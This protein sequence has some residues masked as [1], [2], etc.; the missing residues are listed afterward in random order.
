MRAEPSFLSFRILRS[1]HDDCYDPPTPPSAR[2]GRSEP[3][4]HPYFEIVI[5]SNY[6]TAV[7]E[8][9]SITGLLMLSPVRFFLF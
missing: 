3:T 7:G 4:L 2:S 8:G 5:F 9:K 1:I 6:F